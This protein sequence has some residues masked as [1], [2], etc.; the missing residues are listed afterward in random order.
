MP[1]SQK[2]LFFLALRIKAFCISS[3]QLPNLGVIAAWGKGGEPVVFSEDHGQPILQ[4][5]ER[6]VLFEMH[7]DNSPLQ[8]GN[9]NGV[10]RHCLSRCS[11]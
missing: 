6:Y 7:F 1:R 2:S 9:L 10:F 5:N 3:K 11:Y 8:S 4:N